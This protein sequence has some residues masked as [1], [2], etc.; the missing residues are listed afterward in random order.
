MLMQTQSTGENKGAFATVSETYR[1]GGIRSLYQGLSSP[2]VGAM[3]GMYFC[4][5]LF[6]AH[7]MQK[8][9]HFLWRMVRLRSN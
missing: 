8:M 1:N 3:A 5:Y 4:L 2:L 7:F 6:K 9:R